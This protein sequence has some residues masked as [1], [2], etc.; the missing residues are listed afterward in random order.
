[1]TAQVVM[2]LE[3]QVPDVDASFGKAWAGHGSPEVIKRRCLPRPLV[4]RELAGRAGGWRNIVGIV[5]GN[6]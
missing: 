3:W 2:P 1:M 4:E 5:G 6:R